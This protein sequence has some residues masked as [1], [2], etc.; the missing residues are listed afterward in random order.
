MPSKN[1]LSID[2]IFDGRLS[3]AIL[4]DGKIGVSGRAI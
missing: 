2:H 1:D 3:S 4:F